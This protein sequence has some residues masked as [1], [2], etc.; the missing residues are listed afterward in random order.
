MPTVASVVITKTVDELIGGTNYREYS[1]AW[2]ATDG[3]VIAAGAAGNL[4]DLLY[5]DI[6]SIVLTPGA[7]VSSYTISVVDSD[8]ATLITKATASTSVVERIASDPPAGCF[9]K[10]LHLVVSGAGDA[11]TGTLLLRLKQAM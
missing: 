7:G 9:G 4:S 2:V 6:D 1:F 5:G 11:K 3:G 8:G 10:A